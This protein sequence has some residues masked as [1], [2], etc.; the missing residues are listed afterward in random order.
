MF[1]HKRAPCP[2]EKRKSIE[3]GFQVVS[4]R[5]AELIWTHVLGGVGSALACPQGW[6]EQTR[7]R[8]GWNYL[9]VQGLTILL[10]APP[11]TRTSQVGNHA[12]K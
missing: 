1:T 6:Q 4:I 9:S 12:H 3:A 2:P 10:E 5:L 7:W 11:L 8:P